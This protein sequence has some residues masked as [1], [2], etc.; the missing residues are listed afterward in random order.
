MWTYDYFQSHYNT[1]LNP[2]EEMLFRQS[3]LAGDDWNYDARGAWLESQVYPIQYAN[4]HYPDR[5][6]KPNHP[7]FSDES[8]YHGVNDW[9]GGS[10]IKTQDGFQGY[11]PGITNVY[12][13]EDLQRYM[14]REE[15]AVILLPRW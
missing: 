14:L 2:L 15:P 4:G 13:L 11:R 3:P 9:Y 7:T 5:Y 8:I 1:P 6:K 10:W 12:P